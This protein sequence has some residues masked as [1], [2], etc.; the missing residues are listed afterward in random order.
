[1]LV[2]TA[3]IKL[4]GGTK[5]LDPKMIIHENVPCWSELLY[6]ESP[7]SIGLR[8]HKEFIESNKVDFEK[9]PIVKFLAENLKIPAFSQNFNGNIGFGGIL[10]HKGEKDGFIEFMA[11]IPQVKKKTNKKCTD[12]KGT[13]KRKYDHDEKCLF[14]DGTGREW[15][16]DWKEAYAISASFSVLTGWLRFCE[17]ETSATYPQLLTVLTITQQDM[18]GGSLS[19]DISIPMHNW[20]KSFGERV[21]LTGMIRAM[22]IVYDKMYGLTNSNQYHFNAY[23]ASGRFIANCPG[24]ACGLHPSDWYENKDQGLNLVAIMLIIQ[25]NKLCCWP[26]LPFCTIWQ[27]K[28]LNRNFTLCKIFFAKVFLLTKRQKIEFFILFLFLCLFL[29]YFQ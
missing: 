13:G 6:Q 15:T 8:I 12:C 25:C 24:D 20:L 11:E 16:M 17:I 18:H 14:C 26:P 28:K 7:P 5:D 21:E 4:K 29:L 19:G 23:T 3:Q 1:M 27:E 22:K 2:L 10:K 9:A